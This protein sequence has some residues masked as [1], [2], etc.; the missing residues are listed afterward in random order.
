[1]FIISVILIVFSSIFS[2]QKVS[3]KTISK[4]D[5]KIIKINEACDV[6]YIYD[7]R[8]S[9][10]SNEIFLF[11]SFKCDFCKQGLKQLMKYLAK[12]P[13]VAIKIYFFIQEEADL[14]KLL[15]IYAAQNNFYIVLELMDIFSKTNN[16][17]LDENFQAC[18]KKFP[19]L[20]ENLKK[21]TKLYQTYCDISQKKFIEMHVDQAPTWIINNCVYLF[22]PLDKLSQIVSSLARK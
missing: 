3:G 11:L 20:E 2:V 8:E 22:G 18:L 16:F 21:N 17:K 15:Y 14:E 13:K 12:G 5:K 7:K 10:Q 4:I 19:Q 6:P 9:K 1:M